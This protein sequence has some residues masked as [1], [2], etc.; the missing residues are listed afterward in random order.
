M[1]MVRERVRER[2]RADWNKMK[3]ESE[4]DGHGKMRC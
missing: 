4:M 2:E 3:K 1:F